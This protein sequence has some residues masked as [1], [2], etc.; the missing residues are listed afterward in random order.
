MPLRLVVSHSSISSSCILVLYLFL[1]LSF[2]PSTPDRALSSFI[3]TVIH[4]I[5]PFLLLI[6]PISLFLCLPYVFLIFSLSLLAQFSVSFSLPLFITLFPFSH[7]FS[8]F[9]SPIVLVSFFLISVL[10]LLAQSS[11][12][13]PLP[14]FITLFLHLSSFSP[15]YPFPCFPYHIVSPPVPCPWHR[16]TDLAIQ[17]QIGC[18]KGAFMDHQMGS[19]GVAV[20]LPLTVAVSAGLL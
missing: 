20:C 19:K 15:S 18:G 3:F 2:L 13:F 17:M 14:S 4:I 7:S 1:L 6:F 12:P 10:S 16:S 5:S 11:L 9:C 8:P